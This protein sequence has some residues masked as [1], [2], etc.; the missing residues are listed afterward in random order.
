VPIIGILGWGYFAFAADLVLGAER[1][2]ARLAVVIAAPAAAHLA[3]LAS[4]W[5]LFRWT[6]RGDLG[7]A[8]LAAVLALGALATAWVAGR[9]AASRAI[10]PATALPRA[11]AAALFVALLVATAP[12][13]ARLWLHAAALSVPYGWASRPLAE[14][15]RRV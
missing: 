6:L 1:P 11:T 3:I 8:S 13:D 7:D 9:R 5:G 2:G 12:G 15:A 10:P 4:W 14:P